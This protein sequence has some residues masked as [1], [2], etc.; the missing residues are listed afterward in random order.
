MRARVVVIPELDPVP[1][2]TGAGDLLSLR[3]AAEL[4]VEAWE[5]REL[6]V[7]TSGAG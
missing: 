3:V 2:G 5:V 4:Q 1:A 6:E 7:V